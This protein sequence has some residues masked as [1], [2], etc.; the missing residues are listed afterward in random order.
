MDE[1]RPLAVGSL[2]AQAGQYLDPATGGVTPP[3]QPS[4][5]FARDQDY[6][7]LGAY[8]YS[9]YGNPTYDQVERL[10]AQLDGGAAALV[11]IETPANPTW[12]VIDIAASCSGSRPTTTAYGWRLRSCRR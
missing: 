12:D 5:T 2:L 10:A 6:E 7:L 9:R 1:T 3:I 11:W 4:T 8:V